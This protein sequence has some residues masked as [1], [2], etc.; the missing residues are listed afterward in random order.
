LGSD[1]ANLANFLSNETK[2]VREISKWLLK[3]T[4]G[5]YGLELVKLQRDQ[6]LHTDLNALILVDKKS[7]ITTSFRDV[8]IGLSQV[9]PIITRLVQLSAPKTRSK[10]QT[11]RIQGAHGM[12]NSTPLLLVEQP[13][14][15]LH[16]RMQL[17]LADLFVEASAAGNRNGPQLI[18]ETHSENLILRVQKLVREG[19][20]QNE[21]VSV[22][23]VD[24]NRTTGKSQ[25]KALP[26]ADNGEFLAAWPEDFADLRLEELL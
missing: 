8:G 22:L 9:L 6:R 2:L 19:K 23:Y 12:G 15:H 13:E 11:K 24:R 17:Q 20:L 3:F 10:V 1:A 4:E 21:A 26:L 18:V 7:K 14:L 25:V 5:T 16:P